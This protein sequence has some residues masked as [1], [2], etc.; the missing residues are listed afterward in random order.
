[1]RCATIGQKLMA[2]HDGELSASDRSLMEEHLLACTA[3]RN[4]LDALRLA[5]SVALPEPGPDYWD[6]FTARVMGGIPRQAPAPNRFLRF[7]SFGTGWLHFAPAAAAA[8]LLLA[9]GGYFLDVDISLRGGRHETAP[10]EPAMKTRAQAGRAMDN[11][12]AQDVGAETTKGVGADR[13][14]LPDRTVAS[15]AESAAPNLPVRDLLRR[16]LAGGELL[17]VQVLNIRPDGD[18]YEL[19]A[20]KS[21]LSGS[22]LLERSRMLREAVSPAGDPDLVRLLDDLVQAMRALQN[23]SPEDFPMVQ[24]EIRRAGVLERAA[25]YKVLL[26]GGGD[27]L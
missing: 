8:V 16:N 10:A 25:A 9:A 5:D 26:S 24:Q 4:A 11:E 13:L 7:P 6:E 23:A 2:Y 21:D 19:T 22:G 15:S 1:M 20:L 14:G 17:L 12:A 18:R 27:S 3:C